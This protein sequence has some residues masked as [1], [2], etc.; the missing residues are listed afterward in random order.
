MSIFTHCDD[1][2][3]S[4]VTLKWENVALSLAIP[5]CTT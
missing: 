1:Y 4:G 2:Q 3:I 5:L